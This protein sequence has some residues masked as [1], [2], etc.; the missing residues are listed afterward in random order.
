M[1]GLST[2]FFCFGILFS[3]TG[4]NELTGQVLDSLT[5][6][7][8]PFANVF[9][10]N[11]SIGTVTDDQGGF[12]LRNFKSGKYDLIV[13]FVGYKKF[14]KSLTFSEQAQT[15]NVVLKPEATQL[16]E[17]VVSPDFT[18]RASD[19]KRFE[20]YF[21]GENRNAS[22]CKIINEKTLVVY[23]DEDRNALIAF[24]RSPLEIRNEALGYKLIYDLENFEINFT[25]LTQNYSG[26][27][28]F[29]ELTPKKLA[30]KRS[31]DDER[32]R[33]YLGSF[34]HLIHCLRNGLLTKPFVLH[35]LHQRPNRNRPPEELLKEK[36]KFWRTKYLS[37][38]GTTT[39]NELARDSMQYFVNLYNQPLVVDSVGKRITKPEQL[40][41]ETRKH[42]VYTGLLHIIYTGESEESEYI[43]LNHGNSHG[44]E[45]HSTIFIKPGG[46]AIYDNGYYEPIGSV[47]FDGYMMW[48]DWISNLLPREYSPGP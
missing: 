35:E 43:K 33:A 37:N 21:I 48:S 24:A 2:L 25:S 28:R 16:N 41:D 40:L 42:I 1:K 31:W 10:A 5:R 27:P 44:Q 22:T 6:Q 38:R 7:P 20:K 30:Q 14:E 4:Q 8:V 29:E 26:T 39:S 3:A 46:V 47:F 17:V 45:Q 12:V 19:L 23:Q 9:F 34:T 32:K 15:L 11:T 36:V 18:Q 13:S